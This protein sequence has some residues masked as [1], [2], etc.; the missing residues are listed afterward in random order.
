MSD[1]SITTVVFASCFRFLNTITVTE[2]N[3]FG[4][5]FNAISGTFFITFNGNQL[6]IPSVE[7]DNRITTPFLVDTASTGDEFT[8]VLREFV[9]GDELASFTGSFS[10][11]CA[12]GTGGG[13][14]S[15][16]VRRLLCDPICHCSCHDKNKSKKSCKFCECS[17]RNKSYHDFNNYNVATTTNQHNVPIKQLNTNNRRNKGCGCG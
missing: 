3:I 8:I 10:S 12:G 17:Q 7:S 16:T 14:G 15:R 9:T 13:G 6:F 4:S 11:S 2:V 1:A 5:G